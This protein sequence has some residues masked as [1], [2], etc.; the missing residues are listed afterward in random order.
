MKKRIL[1]LALAGTTAFSVFGGAMSANAAWWDD[2]SS[3]VNAYDG[4]Y[5]ESL[6][7]SGDLNWSINTSGDD[8]VELTNTFFYMGSEASYE[9][10]DENDEGETIVDASRVV[11][12]PW[13][14]DADAADPGYD[15][16]RNDI[17]DYDDDDVDGYQYFATFEDLAEDLGYTIY[18][19]GDNTWGE[20]GNED[21]IVA[22]NADD[23]YFIFDYEVWDEF[24]GDGADREGNLTQIYDNSVEEGLL[25]Y[26]PENDVIPGMPDEGAGTPRC[27]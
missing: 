18:G 1:A 20:V 26:K 11:M 15:G 3:H 2:L 22:K 12:P 17:H 7:P 5:Y 24:Y 13:R 16:L 6:T 14:N 4:D 10:L 27:V 21:Y 8:Y 19:V 9:N 25:V 23:E